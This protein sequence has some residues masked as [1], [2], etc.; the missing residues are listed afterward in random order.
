[1]VAAAVRIRKGEFEVAHAALSKSRELVRDQRLQ[2][3]INFLE[4]QLNH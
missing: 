1:M 3:V 4:K 2:R